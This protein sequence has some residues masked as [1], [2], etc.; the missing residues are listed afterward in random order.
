MPLPLFD[1]FINEDDKDPSGVSGIALVDSPAIE[2]GYFAF[3]KHTNLRQIRITCGS[4]KGNFVPI[5]ADKQILC[6]ALML[7]NK[8]IYRI[9]EETKQEYEVRFTPETIL[10]IQRK[11]KRLNS[12]VINEMHDPKKVIKGAYLYQDF[13]IDR[14][15]GVMPPLGQSHLQDGDWF[16]WVYEGDK[17][18]W[19]E[20]IRTGVYT[21]FSVEG[22]FYE[23]PVTPDITDEMIEKLK[24]AFK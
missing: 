7:S 4:E 19:D 8:P 13:I 20:F 5:D 21:G 15:I 9:D 12:N 18:I 17:K 23:Q 14:S 24:E 2:Q 16:G 3:N 22:N 10:K 6:G 1:L 11:F